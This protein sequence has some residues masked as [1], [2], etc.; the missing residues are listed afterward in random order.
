[1][2]ISM[3]ASSFQFVDAKMD[4]N[5]YLQEVDNVIAQKVDGVVTCIPDQKMSQVVV[6]ELKA[7]NIPVVA[8]DDALQDKNGKQI[9][10]WV[11]ID[12]E[13]LGK[14]LMVPGWQNML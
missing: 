3:G 12:G 4:P 8:V 13:K 1:M 11:G 10:P 14:D 2:A 9:T 7:A 5:T 6:N